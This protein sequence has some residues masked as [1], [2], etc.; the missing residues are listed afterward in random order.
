LVV[1]IVNNPILNKSQFRRSIFWIIL[2][3][4][5][6]AFA[7]GF[8]IF[9][10]PSSYAPLVVLLVIGGVVYFAICLAK[11]VIALYTAL[12]FSLIPAGMIQPETFHSWVNRG[13]VILAFVVW[14]FGVIVRREKIYLPLTSALTLIFLAWA[15]ATLLWA[16]DVSVGFQQIQVYLFRFVIF[17]LLIPNMIRSHARLNQL[18]LVIALDGLALLLA[19]MYLLFT[20]G[21]SPGVRFTIFA[22]NENMVGVA[23]M[24][25]LVGVLWQAAKAENHRVLWNFIAGAYLLFSIGITA[26]SGS[27][28]STISLAVMMAAFFLWK[29]TRKWTYIALVF[30]FIALLIFPG[31]F[32]TMVERFLLT[33]GDTLMN[34][35]EYT[36][37][38]S[39]Q[40][41]QSN[42]LIGTG[43]G[44]SRFAIIP[45]L[46]HIF[47]DQL[48]S[49]AVH[50]PILTIWVE[51]GL[52]G[53][54]LFLT[55]PAAAGF[56]FIKCFQG[57]YKNQAAW[58]EPYFA[59]ISSIT[60]G[61]VISWYVGGGLQ[62]DFSYF[63]I[64][65]LLILPACVLG[66][67]EMRAGQT[68]S[69]PVIP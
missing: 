11:P 60:A 3:I 42:P 56:S 29:P 30:L 65:S 50:N 34:G 68:V 25:T 10:I 22:V 55:I 26:I 66:T 36:W 49:A 61:Y 54:I 20:K 44:G 6:G 18:M 51:T 52:I 57:I 8:A 45:Y 33:Q 62:A 43:I 1:K 27:R 47:S 38:A 64:L 16:G 58:L 35:R 17:L 13:L 48:S 28:G 46:Q 7:S 15:V 63:L 24:M 41:I 21:Y 32:T 53:L 2:L 19:S 39:W 37:Q 4:L 5:L 31:M 14:I 12:F 23:A 67:E 69:E 9:A 40:V 59:I